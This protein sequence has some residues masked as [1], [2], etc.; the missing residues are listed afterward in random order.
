MIF[1]LC[2]WPYIAE[3]ITAVVQEKSSDVFGLHGL[4]M[5]VSRFM[6]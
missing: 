2:Y 1:R 3:N 5:K 6:I 4:G